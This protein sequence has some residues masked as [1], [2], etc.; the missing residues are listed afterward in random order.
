MLHYKYWKGDLK[1]ATLFDV[2]PLKPRPRKP[3]KLLW[4]KPPR[5]LFKLNIDGT[6]KDAWGGLR[7]VIRDAQG[8]I[9]MVVGF[10]LP[11]TSALVAELLAAYHIL[12]WCYT[13]GFTDLRV[14]TDSLLLY[15]M[16]Q[17]KKA[18]WLPHNMMVHVLSFL[19][20]SRSELIHVW[21]EQ[22][23]AADWVAKAALAEQQSFIWRPGE[24]NGKLR[25][26]CNLESRVS[27]I[28]AVDFRFVGPS[29]F[30][31]RSKI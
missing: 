31:C 2:H 1:V 14:E 12:D 23:Q 5:G 24:V 25:T 30:V 10:C 18:H 27:P 29:C 26:L 8:S 9:V 21:R 7:G 20:D 11:G 3:V 19:Q 13:R 28:S 17:S 22:N 16:V 6:F 4:A 15:R